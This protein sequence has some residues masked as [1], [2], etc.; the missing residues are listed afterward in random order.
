M[1]I[2]FPNSFS[3]YWKPVNNWFS[4][5]LFSR[6]RQ[7]QNRFNP[8][9]LWHCAPR[10]I[11]F[12]TKIF[13]TLPLPPL[14]NRVLAFPERSH[15]LPTCG[16]GTP[17]ASLPFLPPVSPRFSCKLIVS[18]VLSCDSLPLLT[19]FFC[20]VTVCRFLSHTDFISHVF[21][22]IG[23]PMISQSITSWATG[24]D[25]ISYSSCFWFAYSM[26]SQSAPF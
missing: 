15:V 6:N 1:F 8:K 12:L 20:E 17:K 21:F 25:V 2:A 18:H 5:F 14:V 7:K 10:Q 23:S 26:S 9:N 13:V 19:M 3:F 4:V 24:R 22:V 11:F 16:Q